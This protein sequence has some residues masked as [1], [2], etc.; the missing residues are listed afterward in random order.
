MVTYAP[1][2]QNATPHTLSVVLTL[3]VTAI[4]VMFISAETP[5]HAGVGRLVSN[6]F[7]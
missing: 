5:S 7:S 3:P 4:V 1:P 2:P 6:V